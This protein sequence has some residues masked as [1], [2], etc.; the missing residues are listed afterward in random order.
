M[1][2]DREARERGYRTAALEG[3]LI[4]RQDGVWEPTAKAD[5]IARHGWEEWRKLTRARP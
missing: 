1:T 2:D 5:F 4:Q 3:L